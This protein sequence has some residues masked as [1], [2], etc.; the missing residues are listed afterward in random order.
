MRPFLLFAFSLSACILFAQPNLELQSFASG[1][2]FPVDITHA[3]DERLFIVEKAGRIRIIDDNGATLPQPFLDITGR[4]NAQASERGL[5]GLAFHPD[6]AN[7]GYFYV[8][9]TNNSGNTR[10]SRF[11][12]TADNS[13]LADPNSELNLLEVGPAALRQLIGEMLYGVRAT[14]GIEQAS[15]I[16]LV[17]Q[18]VVHI[19]GNAPRKIGGRP[20]RYIEGGDFNAVCATEGRGK[21]FGGGA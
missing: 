9:Y 11:S 13:N 1:F 7:N 10:I 4:V 15:Q 8:N 18:D 20:L 16:D 19:A 21:R 5:L 3:G 2:S 12:V 6:Y 17:L 14:G